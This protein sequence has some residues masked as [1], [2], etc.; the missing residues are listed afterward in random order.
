MS[1]GRGVLGALL[2]AAAGGAFAGL[3]LLL[4]Y[5][6]GKLYLSGHSIEPPWYDTVASICVFGG[7]LLVATRLFILARR[8]GPP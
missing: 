4:L 5:V 2:A 3:C 8:G 1:D 6:I 7:A